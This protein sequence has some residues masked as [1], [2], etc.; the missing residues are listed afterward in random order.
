[1]HRSAAADFDSIDIEGIRLWYSEV[2]IY[3]HYWHPV[4]DSSEDDPAF[5]AAQDI[6]AC[7]ANPP[8]IPEEVQRVQ[9]QFFLGDPH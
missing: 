4:D 6:T 2:P 1:M 5:G 9:A 7:S 3:G 8:A